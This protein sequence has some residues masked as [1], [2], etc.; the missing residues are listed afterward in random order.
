MASAPSHNRGS[1]LICVDS[2]WDCPCLPSNYQ[3][4]AP[5]V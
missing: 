2:E 3:L 4:N 1:A 5:P